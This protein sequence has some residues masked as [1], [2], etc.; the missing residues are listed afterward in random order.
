MHKVSVSAFQCP[1][2]EYNATQKG[3]LKT[4]I[5]SIHEGKTFQCSSCEYKATQKNSLKTHMQ[6]VHE[7]VRFQCPS[8]LCTHKATKK[9]KGSVTYYVVGL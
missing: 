5:Q 9:S 2:C 3:S 4:H 7:G 1:S 6:S 8:P